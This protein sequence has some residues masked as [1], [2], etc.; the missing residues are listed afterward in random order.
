MF[1]VVSVLWLESVRT[2]NKTV[3]TKNETV[4]TKN[5]TV[6]TKNH[7]Y[8]KPCVQKAKRCVQN[9]RFET[10]R[11]VKTVRFPSPCGGKDHRRPAMLRSEP[12]SGAAVAVSLKPTVKPPLGGGPATMCIQPLPPPAR[13]SASTCA[14]NPVWGLHREIP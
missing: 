1:F 4:R 2:K 8:K 7:A 14:R 11:F 6:R 5:K 3:R 10:V 12:A 9:A 13:R